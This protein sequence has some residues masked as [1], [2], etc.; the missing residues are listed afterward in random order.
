MAAEAP[1]DTPS[2]ILAPQ[3]GHLP[4]HLPLQSGPTV[5]HMPDASPWVA[6]AGPRPAVHRSAG[7]TPTWPWRVWHSLRTVLCNRLG[8]W[9][10]PGLTEETSDGPGHTPELGTF[11]LNCFSSVSSLVS[12]GE[13]S[14]RQRRF[15]QR[16]MCSSSGHGSTQGKCTGSQPHGAFLFLPGLRQPEASRNLTWL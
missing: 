12:A 5:G 14:L 10:Q 9:H 4:A 1:E 7:W 8:G 11:C 15:S 6:M 3:P 16:Q 2:R 13:E